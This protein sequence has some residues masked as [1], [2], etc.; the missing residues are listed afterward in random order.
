MVI[1][2]KQCYFRICYKI[3]RIQAQM[4]KKITH[5]PEKTTQLSEQ[6]IDSYFGI[7]LKEVDFSEFNRRDINNEKNRSVLYE[8]RGYVV[9][10]ITD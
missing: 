8:R 3:L 7:E 9:E 6:E 5:S 4:Y 10:H 1:N 2:L